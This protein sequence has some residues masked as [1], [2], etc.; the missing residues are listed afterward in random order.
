MEAI[1][2]VSLEAITQNY[3]Y[4]QKR[5]HP[6]QVIPV[7]KA[8]AYG[9]GATEITQHLHTK[10]GVETFAVATIEEAQ[11]LAA[12]FPEISILIFSR[13]FPSE[14]HSVPENA[15][16]TVGSME[17]AQAL[18]NSDVPRIRVHLNI[19]TGMNRIGLSS[20]EAIEL[21]SS[22]D[23]HLQIEGVYSHFSSSDTVSEIAYTNQNREFHAIAEKLLTIGFQGM[24]HIANSAAGLHEQQ[25]PYDAIRLG[26]G[27]YGYDTTP[28]GE[29]QGSLKP[30]MTIKAP[31][32]RVARIQASESVSYAEKWQTSID[33][34]I[35][36]LRIGYADGYVRAL[37][38]R[39]VV[40]HHG[41]MYPVVGTVTMD[42]IMI[43]LG[44]DEPQTGDMFDVM[45]GEFP[46]VQVNTI[47]KILATIPYEI[48]CAI[49]P[50]VKR[51]Y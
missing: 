6:A 50:R 38:N 7:V 22:K 8:N 41:K 17:D 28:D 32:I 46:E 1:C 48:C 42:H 33:T 2:Q 35:G 37:T 18:L 5:V 20:Q 3:T 31:L 26:I 25:N 39:G 9:H 43:D 44:N 16:L 40:S 15:I 12:L 29:H 4:F 30:A 10:L 51:Q 11:E 19:N 36:T 49:S 27:L 24:I 14:L 13:V 21:I 34:N 47:S 45:G 23:S